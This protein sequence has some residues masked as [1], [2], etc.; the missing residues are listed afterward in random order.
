MS[1]TRILGII[2]FFTTILTGCLNQPPHS[3]VPIVGLNHQGK[4]LENF[5]HF[6]KQQGNMTRF[7]QASLHSLEHNFKHLT[8]SELS[9]KE[10][11]LNLALI[12][13][14]SLGPSHLTLQSAGR[15][16]FTKK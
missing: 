7:M 15:L 16:T 1:R 5:V 8:L 9:L 3:S 4:L 13:G 6:Q 14:A 10:V 11:D 2:V 12:I